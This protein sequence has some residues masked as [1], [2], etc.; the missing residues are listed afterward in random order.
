MSAIAAENYVDAYKKLQ[1]LGDY[2]DS[3]EQMNK[4]KANYQI[5]LM[6][7]A[8]IDDIVCL[9]SFK[10]DGDISKDNE[11]LRWKVIDRDGNKI[12][13]ITCDIIAV[14]PYQSFS[15]DDLSWEKSSLR[16]WL[17]NDFYNLAFGENYN[18]YIITTTVIPSYEIV[19]ST[20]KAY[21]GNI[22]Q[23][24]VFLLSEEEL[25]KYFPSK[26]GRA[27]SSICNTNNDSDSWLLRDLLYSAYG[28]LTVRVVSNSGYRLGSVSYYSVKLPVG[29]RPVIWVDVE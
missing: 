16:T 8:A 1:E 24:K 9:G 5:E 7:N 19:D 11:D 28:A 12:M 6:E 26:G 20:E 18:D 4:I 3:I 22:T 10:E 15:V 23:D 13:L 21:Y 17:N 2:K 27:A 14:R 29:V 25:T